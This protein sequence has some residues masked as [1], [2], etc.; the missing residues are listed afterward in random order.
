VNKVALG[1]A[2]AEPTRGLTGRGLHHVRQVISMNRME[3]STR[4]HGERF[5]SLL[6]TLF[7]LYLLMLSVRYSDYVEMNDVYNELKSYVE[8][9]IHGIIYY[10][11]YYY[12]KILGVVFF[13]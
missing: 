10:Y 9:N 8:A 2:T 1:S 5:M 12:L 13:F 4:R 11:Y 7:V 3:P 6:H